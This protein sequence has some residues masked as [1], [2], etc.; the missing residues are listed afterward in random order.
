M[1]TKK[2]KENNIEDT[3]KVLD[4]IEEVK[5]SPFFKDKTM[6]RLFAA[7]EVEE[8]PVFGWFTPKVQLA[9]LV[10]VLILNVI[11]FSKFS[12]SDYASGVNEFAETYGLSTEHTTSLIN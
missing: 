3:F 1:N 12:Q 10:C 6:Q 2:H 8:K 11:V 5:V 4:S 9:T 7:E